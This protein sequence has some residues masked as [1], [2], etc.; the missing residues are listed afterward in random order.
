[1]IS[2]YQIAKHYLWRRI[3]IPNPD[4]ELKITEENECLSNLHICNASCC[5]LI[6]FDTFACIGHPKVDYYKKRGLKVIRKTREIITVYVP[7]KCIHLT[8]TNKCNLH[9][10]PDKPKVCIG[11]NRESSKN[12]KYVLT[13]GC[14][15]GHDY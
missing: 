14:I 2:Y 11:Y 10:T 12:G 5:K 3:L 7:H 6:C 1:M 15:Y 8:S 4:K 9:G 13:E